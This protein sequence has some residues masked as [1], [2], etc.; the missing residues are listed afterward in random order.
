VPAN[1]EKFTQKGEEML[2]MYN[3]EEQQFKKDM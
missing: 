3:I 2:S 1:A